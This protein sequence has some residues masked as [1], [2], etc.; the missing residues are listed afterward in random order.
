[1]NTEIKFIKDF[2]NKKKGDVVIYDSML[3]SRLVRIHKV[4]K[5]NKTKTVKE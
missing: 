2:A 1:M 4:A 3:S 5:I